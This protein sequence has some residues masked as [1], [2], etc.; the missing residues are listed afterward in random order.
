[1]QGHENLSL[2]SGNI[3]I[4]YYDQLEHPSMRFNQLNKS[5]RAEQ[6]SVLVVSKLD[7]RSN[8]CGFESRLIQY[9]RWKWGI[10]HARINYFT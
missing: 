2:Y 1:M 5:L 4:R 8:D 6:K 10:S 9:T 3:I 7:L